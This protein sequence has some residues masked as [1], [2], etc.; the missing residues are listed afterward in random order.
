MKTAH[1]ILPVAAALL[2]TAA[3]SQVLPAG[4]GGG[5]QQPAGNVD[6]APQQPHRATSRPRL[7]RTRFATATVLRRAA[8]RVAPA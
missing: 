1:V 4:G 8:S 5:T 2:S 6:T 3:F 7:Y